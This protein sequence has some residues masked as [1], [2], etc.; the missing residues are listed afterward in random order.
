[1]GT[2]ASALLLTSAN[3]FLPDILILTVEQTFKNN[4]SG[5]TIEI[6][7]H[8]FPLATLPP[9]FLHQ[10]Q[11]SEILTSSIFHV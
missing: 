6:G 8:H 3:G 9:Q 4:I 7:N 11:I 5:N 2:L 10:L 1:M